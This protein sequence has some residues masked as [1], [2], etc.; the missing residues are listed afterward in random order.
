MIFPVSS[1]CNSS[2]NLV[3]HVAARGISKGST[4][5][6]VPCSRR[7]RVH[8]FV[9]SKMIATLPLDGISCV[10]QTLATIKQSWMPDKGE[11]VFNSPCFSPEDSQ[12]Y[13]ISRI[14]LAHVQLSCIRHSDI[15]AS[16][17]LYRALWGIAA[18]HYTQL[19]VETTRPNK[20]SGTELLQLI[21]PA[22]VD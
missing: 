9:T 7:L 15:T 2:G 8:D 6:L 17:L 1:R 4:M 18:L 21:G 11:L 5:I 16:E 20:I 19:S 22:H 3:P 12:P 13:N 10:C 14:A